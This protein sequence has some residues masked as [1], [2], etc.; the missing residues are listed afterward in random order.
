MEIFISISLFLLRPDLELKVF[1][2]ENNKT[3]LVCIDVKYIAYL[4][5][6]LLYFCFLVCE[7]L[8]AVRNSD[9]FTHAELQRG[10]CS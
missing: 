9:A 4:Y 6:Q 1:P 5:A 3:E 8:C 2:T 10:C 7:M